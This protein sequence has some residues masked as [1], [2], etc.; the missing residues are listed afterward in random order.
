MIIG[1]DVH[2][3]GAGS[4]YIG[5]GESH[6]DDCKGMGKSDRESDAGNNDCPYDW[7]GV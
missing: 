1:G 7:L 3:R 5:P 4:P 2:W 6:N